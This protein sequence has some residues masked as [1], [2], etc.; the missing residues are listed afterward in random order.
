MERS[1][2]PVDAVGD[3]ESVMTRADAFDIRLWLRLL[4]CTTLIERDLRGLLTREFDTTLPRFD[5]LAQ[6]ERAPSGLT[7]GALSRRM[8]VTN[9]NVTGVVDRL[10]RDGLAR[11]APAK[12]DRRAS[13]VT[14]TE[15]GR[16]L[17]A[18]MTPVHHARVQALLAGFDQRDAERLFGLLA[19]LKVSVGDGAPYPGAARDRQ[20]GS[21]NG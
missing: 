15:A 21:L 9:G 17:F 18:T 5:A 12:E 20:A 11:R 16:R 2:E 1:A 4:T 10:V 3:H 7:M 14:L 19:Q 13:I 8:M 6:L